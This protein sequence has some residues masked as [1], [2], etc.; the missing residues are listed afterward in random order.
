MQYKTGI[1]CQGAEN[2]FISALTSRF[3]ISPYFCS[4]I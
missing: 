2:A 1:N 3:S 4:S